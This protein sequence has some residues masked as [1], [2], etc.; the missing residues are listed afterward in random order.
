MELETLGEMVIMA[1][2]KGLISVIVPTYNAEKTIERCIN[3]LTLQSYSNI[4]IIVVNDGSTDST[5]ILLEQLAH[6]D[7][8]IRLI[9]KENGGVSSARNVGL[10]NAQGEYITFVDSDDWVEIDFLQH[11]YDMLKRTNADIAAVNLQPIY[12][13]SVYHQ[14]YS[15]IKKEEY[16]TDFS[17]I[18]Q[19]CANMETYTCCVA[20][21]LIRNS[22]IGDIRFNHLRYAEDAYFNRRVFQNAHGI[23]KMTYNEYNYNIHEESASNVKDRFCDNMSD[24]LEMQFY[25]YDLCKSADGKIDTSFLEWKILWDAAAMCIGNLDRMSYPEILLNYMKTDA[26][27]SGDKRERMRQLKKIIGQF[28]F[29]SLKKK[30]TYVFLRKFLKSV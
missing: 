8:R 18:L 11:M 20:S 30:L 13:G 3:S 21:K 16:V 10:D 28:S 12:Y 19:Q 1:E 2:Q 25:T 7:E 9:H 4:E 24:D 17:E 29:E 23:V 22:V 5:G 14:K 6:R 27:L 15:L 26:A